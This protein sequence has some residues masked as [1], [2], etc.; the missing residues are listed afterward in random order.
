MLHWI[1]D[2]PVSVGH[3]PLVRLDAVAGGAPATVLAK[4]EGRNAALSIKHRVA[5]AL[6]WDADSRGLLGRGKEIVAP[7]SGATGI[8]LAAI[9]RSRDIPV[10][11]AVPETVS[12]AV[13]EFLVASGATLVL[14]DGALS[15]R[16]AIAKA[17]EIAECDPSRY[18]LMDPFT[19]PVAAAIHE[20]TTGPEIWN[21]TAGA[22]DILVSCVGT[23]GTITGVSRHIKQ[24]RGKAIQSVAVEPAACPVLT[25]TRSGEPLTPGAHKIV[26]V[27]PGFVPDVLDLALVD[28]VEQVDDEEATLYA[29]RLNAEEGLQSGVSS[30]AAVAVAAR[31]ARRPEHAG[32]TIVAILAD[33]TTTT[34]IQF[35]MSA[36]LELP[37]RRTSPLRVVA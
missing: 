33:T 8:A 32:K 16:G 22:I 11:L 36:F 18:V 1:V 31:L 10:T 7:T 28:A 2:S 35:S 21:D 25:Q 13:R 34:S 4:I 14:T 6:I 17:G 37:R 3:T 19:N 9:A 23:G 30:G 20:R 27:G 15:M 29:E 26:G 12:L 5:A 24:S